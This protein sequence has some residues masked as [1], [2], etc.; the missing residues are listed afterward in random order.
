MPRN[1]ENE[2]GSAM[3]LN[4]LSL[5]LRATA[6]QAPP[7][8]KLADEAIGIQLLSPVFDIMPISTVLYIWCIPHTTVSG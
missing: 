3:D 6:K 2:D 5:V 1:A 8:A 7:C 4:F